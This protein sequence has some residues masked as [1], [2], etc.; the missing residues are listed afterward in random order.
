MSVFPNVALVAQQVRVIRPVR[1][2]R[3]EVWLA[4]VLL[5]GVPEEVNT[6]R[7]RTH[8]AFYSPLA[9][10]IHDDLEM[11]TR[12]TEGL[13]CREEPWLLLSRGVH[14]ERRDVDGTVVGQVTDELVQREMWRRWKELMEA[15]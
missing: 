11:F 10:G 6:Q 9:G 12:V 2:D 3:T 1:H 14:R 13:R 15:P 4:A 5:E 8:E 7:I